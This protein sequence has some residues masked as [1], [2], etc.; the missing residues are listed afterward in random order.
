MG[1][2]DRTAAMLAVGSRPP[3]RRSA[4]QSTA[5][6]VRLS[7]MLGAELFTLSWGCRTSRLNSSAG[8]SVVLRMSALDRLN[9]V[10]RRSAFTKQRDEALVSVMRFLE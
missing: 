8:A 5:V 2:L 7:E 6:P 1:E 10:V 4:M 9:N 3:G